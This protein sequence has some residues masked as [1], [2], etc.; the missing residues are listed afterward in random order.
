[1]AKQR[2]EHDKVEP[3]CAGPGRTRG[4]RRGT[5]LAQR[6]LWLWFRFTFERNK[7]IGPTQVGKL[8]LVT[9]RLQIQESDVIRGFLKR[10]PLLESW[11]EE[12]GLQLFLQTPSSMVHSLAAHPGWSQGHRRT[13]FCSGSLLPH[14]AAR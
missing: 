4:V 3:E 11:E 8:L 10:R 2:D 5:G 12:S 9:G 6:A 1:M 14:L 13:C 7:G